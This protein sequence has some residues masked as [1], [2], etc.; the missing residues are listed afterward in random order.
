LIF[1]TVGTHEQPFPRFVELVLSLAG[2][3]RVVIQHGHTAPLAVRDVEWRQWLEP[4]EVGLLMAE[5][6][7]L[8]THAGVGTIV[9]ALRAGHRPIVIPRRRHFGEHVDDHQLQVVRELT[10]LGLV[11]PW[12]SEPRP[13]STRATR[14]ES[15]P[16]S[17]LK[18]VVRAAALGF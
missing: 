1:A 11:T 3:M 5:A 12:P 18:A 17:G 6:T 9:E 4:S 13:V 2:D 7:I 16:P 14:A 8:V 15:W 10:L